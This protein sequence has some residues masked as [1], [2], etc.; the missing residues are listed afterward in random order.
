MC[1]HTYIYIC[2]HIYIYAYSMR[3]RQILWS[4][5]AS[6][7]TSSLFSKGRSN[8]TLVTSVSQWRK[9]AQS[10]FD[11]EKLP[12]CN[13]FDPL[14]VQCA[15]L[16][17]LPELQARGSNGPWAG[18]RD[19]PSLRRPFCPRRRETLR[20]L[21]EQCRLGNECKICKV[22][23][24]ECVDGWQQYQSHHIRSQVW[25]HGTLDDQVLP[26]LSCNELLKHFSQIL[27][28]TRRWTAQSLDARML[29]A[30]RKERLLDTG[31]VAFRV[32]AASRLQTYI[33]LYIYILSYIIMYILLF[34][35]YILK[36]L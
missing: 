25:S 32:P 2:T 1:T 30:Y 22:L 7:A 29:I 24:E 19:N 35:F 28:P 6:D 10:L 20:T 4:S 15:A 11:Y 27:S 16:L 18:T 36:L 26:S 31:C 17:C 33:L 8:V 21:S 5:C 14:A 3:I 13:E 23:G 9:I 12:C 34:L